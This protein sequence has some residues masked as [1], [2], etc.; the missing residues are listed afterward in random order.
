M[1]KYIFIVFAGLVISGTSFAQWSIAPSVSYLNLLVKDGYGNFGLT[2][3]AEKNMLYFGVGY[4]AK[5]SGTRT[6]LADT[7]VLEQGQAQALSTYS[8][9]S[10]KLFLGVKNYFIGDYDSDFGL[11]GL[12]DISY[13]YLPITKKLDGPKDSK[14]YYRHLLF[15]E[16][17]ESYDDFVESETS[18]VLLTGGVGLG[19]EKKIK[20]VYLYSDATIKMTITGPEVQQNSAAGEGGT[21]MF[22]P[23]EFN[24]GIRI[25]LD[26]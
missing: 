20:G 23:L 12:V 1:K 26:Y 24:L 15:G 10:Y 18:E 22:F 25:P 2:I 14:R 5:V 13:Y 21:S 11:Y 16:N 17:K 19:L 6:V 7:M 9:K 8:M 4:N 3:K